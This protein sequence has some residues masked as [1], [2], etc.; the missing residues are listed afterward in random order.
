M[1]MRILRESKDEIMTILE[2]LVFDPLYNWSLT[3]EKAFR[4]QFGRDPPARSAK[5]AKKSSE[6]ESNK[7]AERVLMRVAQKLDGMEEGQLMSLEGQVNALIQQ[8]R[9]P[10]RLCQLFVGWQAYI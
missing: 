2:V 1:T 5:A 6:A 9:D 10:A 7:M 4:I 8:A 3:P